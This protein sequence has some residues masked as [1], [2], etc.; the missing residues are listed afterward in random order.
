MRACVWKKV[1]WLARLQAR[2]LDG[3]PLADRRG[4]R[5][6]THL[7]EIAAEVWDL[8]QNTT[9]PGE[10]ISVKKPASPELPDP[11]PPKDFLVVPDEEKLDPSPDPNLEGKTLIE[12]DINVPKA[13]HSGLP[14]AGLSPELANE[15]PSDIRT[16]VQGE[17]AGLNSNLDAKLHD[18]VSDQPEVSNLTVQEHLV[19]TP[20]SYWRML[21]KYSKPTTA[22]QSINNSKHRIKYIWGIAFLLA[23]L[24]MAVIA[25]VQRENYFNIKDPHIKE[26][27]YQVPPA[28]QVFPSLEASTAPSAV[29]PITVILDF[30]KDCWIEA[31][32]DNKPSL[33]ELRIQ[34]ESLTLEAQKSVSLTLGNAGA[35]NVRVNGY[36]FP[37]NKK[38][39][40]VVKGLLID[41]NTVKNL[42][43]PGR[44]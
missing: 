30:T 37:L 9:E 2:P 34:G 20:T 8:I 28:Q 24:T 1:P 26:P 15:P 4:A 29:K 42:E 22:F 18:I 16:S 17:L 36:A 13:T 7:A 14:F 6:E 19:E 10:E 32:I 31:R 39:G 33:A 41:L 40:E 5:I 44:K 35:V 23:L 3:K 38:D 25:E 11:Q 43:I 21:L 12:A 27:P